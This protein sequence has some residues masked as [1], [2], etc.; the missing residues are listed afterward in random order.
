M[1]INFKIYKQLFLLLAFIGFSLHSQAQMRGGIDNISDNS[2]YGWAC[3]RL[4]VDAM[5]ISIYV[6]GDIQQGTL[7]KRMQTNSRSTWYV[8]GQCD[9]TSYQHGF[10]YTFTPEQ[11]FMFQDQPI[12]VYV[13][14]PVTDNPTL[15]TSSGVY[16]VPTLSDDQVVLFEDHFDG[17]NRSS[18]RGIAWSSA[19][20]DS[21]ND[22]NVFETGSGQLKTNPHIYVVPDHDFSNLD[23]ALHPDTSEMRVKINLSG[24]S[25]DY[26]Y[27]FALGA[28]AADNPNDY[29][30]Y[31]SNI[32][33]SV[34]AH[35][36]SLTLR[37]R[38]RQFLS[39]T[40]IVTDPKTLMLTTVELRITGDFS[41]S[42]STMSADVYVNDQLLMTNILFT[43]YA[44]QNHLA[45]YANDWVTNTT[46]L[47]VR[48]D[49]VRVT[50]FRATQTC[51]T[52]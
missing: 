36:A 17:I 15:L 41:L 10:H 52:N 34:D 18:Q 13:H 9:Y 48:Y 46:L 16:S 21:Y 25:Q 27:Y 1:K 6:G 50:A 23:D 7:V 26:T 37:G 20:N 29:A 49:S 8:R 30:D 19:P 33:L 28:P 40:N 12:Y 22:P 42:S 45:M 47:P 51:P 35:Q 2:I 5:D 14:E 3:Q 44:G 24:Y 32:T 43:W 11:Q 4:N 31:L 38:S 39:S